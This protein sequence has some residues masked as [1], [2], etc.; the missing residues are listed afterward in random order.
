MESRKRRPLALRLLALPL[1]VL[2]GLVSGQ[3]LGAQELDQEGRGHA[4]KGASGGHTVVEFAASWCVPC[5]SSLPRLEALAKK[6]PEIRMLVISVDDEVAGRDDL[7]ES[8][9]LKLPVLWDA[10][11]AIAEHY[12]PEGMPTSV[13]LDPEGEEIYREV[14]FNDEKWRRLVAFIEALPP[15]SETES[16]TP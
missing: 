16:K 6:H 1:L 5:R 15:A 9:G 8:L 14:G 10:D 12:Q 11:Y 2:V 4:W 7:V 3:V 13:I